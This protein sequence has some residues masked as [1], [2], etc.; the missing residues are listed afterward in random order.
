MR[1]RP[2]KQ[3]ELRWDMEEPPRLIMA[4]SHDAFVA[5]A[6]IVSRRAHR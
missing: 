3:R 5:F 4:H 6:A 1:K 2:R